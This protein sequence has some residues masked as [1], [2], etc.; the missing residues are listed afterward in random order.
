MTVKVVTADSSIHAAN[1]EIISNVNSIESD[2]AY[3][4]LHVPHG[5]VSYLKSKVLIIKI[6]FF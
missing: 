4:V 5:K 1:E 3:M 2:N 6:L